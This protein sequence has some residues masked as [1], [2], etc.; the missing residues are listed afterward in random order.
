M[1]LNTASG[2]SKTVCKIRTITMNYSASQLV[3]FEEVKDL[4]LG[5]GKPTVKV[6]TQ[7]KIKHKRR[8]A[9]TV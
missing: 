1:L 4:I 6:H 5:M 3:N 8:G 2:R 9:G 7:S